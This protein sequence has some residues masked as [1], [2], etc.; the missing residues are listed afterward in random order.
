VFGTNGTPNSIDPF[1]RVSFEADYYYLQTVD[2]GD[3]CP[4][5]IPE[6][7]R[8]LFVVLCPAHENYKPYVLEDFEAS[9]LE[10]VWPHLIN[11]RWCR[12]ICADDIVVLEE[13]GFDDSSS[14]KDFGEAAVDRRSRFETRLVGWEQLAGD[15]ADYDF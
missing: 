15:F 6:D 14:G 1:D 11:R 3:Q 4:A 7:C 10:V 12:S 5:Q 13:E 8:R 9:D 2:V